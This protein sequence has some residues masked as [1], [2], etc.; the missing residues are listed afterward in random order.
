[1]KNRI[2]LASSSPRR[3]ELFNKITNNFIP[4]K[5]NFD[6]SL[7]KKDSN[8][9][10]IDLVKQLAYNKALEISNQY[11]D[12][13]VIG[14]DTLGEFNNKR[15]FKPNSPIDAFNLLKELTQLNKSHTIYTSYC[16]M[17]NNKVIFQETVS[18]VLKLEFIDDQTI[19]NYIDTGSPL[20]KAGAYG[21]QDK[22]FIKSNLKENSEDYYNVM[23]LPIEHI[24]NALDKIKD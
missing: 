19:K 4:V 1:M 12:E 2:I 17:K 13:Y 5:S 6:E 9:S 3:I 11:K 15:L 24:K 21:V 22:D 14:L 18:T 7:L 20:D 8:L 23:G 10:L 16:I